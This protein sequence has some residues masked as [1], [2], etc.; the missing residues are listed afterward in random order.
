MFSLQEL[1]SF[2]KQNGFIFPGSEIYGGLANTF[3]YG[4]LGCLLKQNIK[5]AWQK[6][7]FQEREDTLLLDSSIILNTKVWEASGHIKN[8][9][10]PLAENKDTNKR[11]RADKLI[12]KHNPKIDV[13]GMSLESMTQYLIKY[14]LLNT[15]NWSTVKQFNLLFQSHQGSVPSNNNIIFLRPE[16]CQG[17]FVNFKN[18]L[19]TSRKRI[20]FGIGQIGKSFRNEITPGNF[21]FRTCEF[22]QMELEFFHHPQ[23]TQKWFDFWKKY[24]YDFLLDLGLKTENLK[25]KDY[26]KTELSH[27]ASN[28]TDILFNFPWGFDELWGISARNDFDLKQHQEHSGI[29]L[30]Y[31]DH[32]QCNKFYPFVIEPSVGVE[33]LLL[34]VMLNSLQ[35]ETLTNQTERILF[36]IHPF[37]APYKVAILPLIKNI[38]RE[39][40]KQIQRFLCNYFEVIYDETQSIGKRY[41]RQDAIGTPYCCTIDNHTLEKNIVSIRDRDS[42]NQEFIP[43]EHLKDYLVDKISF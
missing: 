12:Q 35:K 7:F 6:K 9:T 8:F 40:A 41:R 10:D 39:K 26:N 43:L 31:S 2:A 20:P 33:R 18:I 42:L 34:A 24:T 17:I 27:Y 30:R 4:P 28:T 13:H 15:S 36:K 22:E 1:I 19:N 29:D 11:Y 23:E 21:I 37:L 32:Q 14:R 5:K 25:F 38:H 3:D 16:T